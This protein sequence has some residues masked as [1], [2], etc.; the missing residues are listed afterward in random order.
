MK[1]NEIQTKLLL[2]SEVTRKILN[3]ATSSDQYRAIFLSFV[4]SFSTILSGNMN[5][6]MI[7]KLSMLKLN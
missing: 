3:I 1:Q 7:I 2:L 5:P 4:V 6:V